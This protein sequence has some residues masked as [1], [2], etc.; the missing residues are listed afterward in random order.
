MASDLSYYLVQ[1]LGASNLNLVLLGLV[2]AFL[3]WEIPRFA[4]MFEEDW[5]KGLYPENGKVIDVILLIIGVLSFVFSQLNSE[6]LVQ[7]AYKPLFPMVLA[8]GLVAF[9]LIILLGFVGRFFSRMDEK[10]NVSAFIVQTLLDFFH[11]VFFICFV[12]LV[13]PAVTLIV[14]NFL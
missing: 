1:Y 11:T 13:F 14:S 8:A 7:L 5:I 2:L 10:L 3:V 6:K 9:S 4:K 12:G